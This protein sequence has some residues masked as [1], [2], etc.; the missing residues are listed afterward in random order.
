MAALEFLDK[1]LLSNLKLNKYA[2]LIMPLYDDDFDLG[3]Y[4]FIG[5]NSTKLIM[6]KKIGSY[7]N[8]QEHLKVNDILKEIYNKYFDLIMNP[9]FDQL[10]ISDLEKPSKI[11]KTFIE[12][13]ENLVKNTVF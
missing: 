11:R 9:F 4:A 2:G 1:K 5:T 12:N 7:D 3:A 10:Q 6:I 8:E 13:V